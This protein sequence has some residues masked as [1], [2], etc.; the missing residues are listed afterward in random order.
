MENGRVQPTTLRPIV[1]YGT[2]LTVVKDTSP[3][4]IPELSV[5]IPPDYEEIPRETKT[6]YLCDI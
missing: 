2:L 3:R 5:P 4:Q 1:V 6:A